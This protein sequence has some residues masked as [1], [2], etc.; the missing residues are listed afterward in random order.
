MLNHP[1]VLNFFEQHN[2]NE[3][4]QSELSH[5]ID[6]LLKEAQNSAP[7]MSKNTVITALN[8]F[9][10]STSNIDLHR[11]DDENLQ[12]QSNPKTQ[13]EQALEAESKQ[14]L[15]RYEV[16]SVLGQGGMGQVYEVYD[17][18][19]KRTLA[20]K[21]I[22]NKGNKTHDSE[23]VARFME[24]A[25]ITAQL[26]HPNILPIHEMGQL[27]DGR[28]YFTMEIVHGCTFTEVINS[29]HNISQNGRW[30]TD[31]Q[32]WNLRRILTARSTSRD[33]K[34]PFLKDSKL[35]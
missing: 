3:I 7:L 27:K 9:P 22:Q 12:Q 30:Q 13:D 14:T 26:Q 6:E 23:R 15:D 32:G 8:L 28:L 31:E 25:Q 5:L 35:L 33:D 1:K 20:L 4:I 17:P 11:L 29:V 24:E 18:I 19:L 10:S 16:L 34:G 2:L 21:V